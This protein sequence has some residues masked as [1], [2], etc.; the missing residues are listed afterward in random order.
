VGH[1]LDVRHGFARAE[2]QGWPQVPFVSEPLQRYRRWH[3]GRPVWRAA[4]QLRTAIARAVAPAC[5]LLAI[6]EVDPTGQRIDWY[7]PFEGQA[8]KLSALSDAE[9]GPYWTRST[10][11]T[12]TSRSR[13][14]DGSAAAVQRRTQL[15]P[16]AAPCADGPGRGRALYRG[17]QAGHDLLGFSA[18]PLFRRVP[19]KPT[20]G[21]RPA[22]R[23][24]AIPEA[25][26]AS[27]PAVV[28]AG[29]RS[30]CG[31]GC[32]SACC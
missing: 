32:C 4:G 25:V 16:P 6:P 1:A 9:R 21:P 18:T 8:R 20:V 10:A 24:P 2:E 14:L 11:C 30:V 7:A 29:T 3:G 28:A 22:V 13:R 12:A 27:V 15:R 23:A 19:G 31:S 26:L 5:R 17:R